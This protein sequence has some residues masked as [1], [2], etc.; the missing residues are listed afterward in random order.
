[1]HGFS[2][3]YSFHKSYSSQ[4]SNYLTFRYILQMYQGVFTQCHD[5]ALNSRFS[6]FFSISITISFHFS[7]FVPMGHY[8]HPHSLTIW[9][10]YHPIYLLLCTGHLPS[11][12]F[13]MGHSFFPFLTAF[14]FTVHLPS[15][16]GVYIYTG[17]LSIPFHHLIISLD[18]WG[19][20]PSHSHFCSSNISHF[21][22]TWSLTLFLLTALK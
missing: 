11:R 13:S 21:W 15:L 16:R 20:Y 8:F 7:V 19:T 2:D 3:L 12:T 1:M 9:G 14:H 6:D 22:H 4:V 18:S 17:H 5:V 10:K